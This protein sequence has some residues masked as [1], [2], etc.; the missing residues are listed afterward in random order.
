M[1]RRKSKELTSGTKTCVLQRIGDLAKGRRLLA[2]ALRPPKEQ[3][4]AQGP[5]HSF[6]QSIEVFRVAR[7]TGKPHYRRT[8]IGRRKERYR[9]SLVR[10]DTAEASSIE[11]LEGLAHSLERAGF[12]LVGE[13]EEGG[14]ETQD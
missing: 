8:G 1:P 2:C 10:T 11:R 4:E 5:V 3:V 13:I 9:E 14:A 7:K 12:S 6:G